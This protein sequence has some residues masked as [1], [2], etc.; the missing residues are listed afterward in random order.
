MSE[1]RRP[2]DAP[3]N[4]KDPR[5]RR[6]A[7]H[8][9]SDTASSPAIEK[10]DPLVVREG[11]SS[12]ANTPQRS[13]A[14]LETTLRPNIDPADRE[15]SLITLFSNA[16]D[17]RLLSRDRDY[18]E[19]K[20]KKARAEYERVQ[21]T[22]AQFPLMVHQSAQNLKKVEECYKVAQ[23]E[24]D[25]HGTAERA[26]V[27]DFLRLFVDQPVKDSSRYEALL[28][29]NN[30]LRHQFQSLQSQYS[31][32]REITEKSTHELAKVIAENDD[33][34]KRVFDQEGS[35]KALSQ[36]II[37]WQDS[38]RQV[39]KSV[40]TLR[41]D[42]R[43][44]SKTA[45]RFLEF[46]SFR[47]SAQLKAKAT[48]GGLELVEEKVLSIEKTLS[49]QQK[50]ESRDKGEIALLHQE[51]LR[52]QDGIKANES[53]V[54]AVKKEVDTLRKSDEAQSERIK[55][56]GNNVDQLSESLVDHKTTTLNALAQQMDDRLAQVAVEWDLVKS[57]LCNQDK[58]T[59]RIEHELCAKV[60]SLQQ[61]LTKLEQTSSAIEKVPAVAA[62]T[63]RVEEL[64]QLQKK[65]QNGFES[66][67][68]NFQ[69]LDQRFNSLKTTELH[70]SI[71]A[72]IGP[73][74]PKY[75]QG[76]ID[77]AKVAEEIKQLRNKND[78]TARIA[79]DNSPVKD[80]GVGQLRLDYDALTKQFRESRDKVMLNINELQHTQLRSGNEAS[81]FRE[82]IENKLE[83]LENQIHEL[84]RSMKRSGSSKRPT[85]DCDDLGFSIKARSQARPLERRTTA[86]SER[87][88]TEQSARSQMSR[89]TE[90]VES[91]DESNPEASQQEQE[92]L[93]MLAKFKGPA[94]SSLHTS[95][96]DES[97]MKSPA[98]VR[99]RQLG[100]R[101]RSEREDPKDT[102]IAESEAEDVGRPRRRTRKWDE[103][104]SL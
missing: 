6:A 38:Q 93:G 4:L 37:S 59:E 23:Q 85:P 76:L 25:Q 61:E 99:D 24:A 32:Q 20:V 89:R 28:T 62:L 86:M 22:H 80:E 18:L 72:S 79:D 19:K 84:R 45:E 3:V 16:T 21:R 66:V 58:E 74:L 69:W 11:T 50:D 7:P 87:R 41:D 36:D 33:L 83:E 52:L 30:D 100:K 42:M 31:S 49:L 10:R 90:D 104:A 75:D 77:L 34:K 63:P 27:R 71:L 26:A 43:D 5:L 56:L 102:A 82:N 101:K 13:D 44:T 54:D 65:L 53:G 1:P 94:T 2:S 55:V 15:K 68:H 81:L 40:E 57:R 48:Q 103:R 51:V 91:A 95:V 8:N 96:D 64:E 35:L 92:R 14:S 47:K 17:S 60:T 46:E 67:R 88:Y 78:Q 70:R 9:T 29:E 97:L 73:V 12:G 98:R 39:E